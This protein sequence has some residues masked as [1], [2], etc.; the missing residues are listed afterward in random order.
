VDEALDVDENSGS[1]A[2]LTGDHHASPGGNLPADPD[3]NPDRADA[4][5]DADDRSEAQDL[6]YIDEVA[7]QAP[8]LIPTGE[9]HTPDE[10]HER[11]VASH[12]RHRRNGRIRLLVFVVIIALVAA[13]IVKGL[14]GGHKTKPPK[15]H[16]SPVA[17]AGTGPSHLAVGTASELPGNLL[18]ADRGN[19]RLVVV[20]P[21]GQVVWQYPGAS[22]SLTRQLYPDF[23]F[24]TPSGHEIAITEEGPAV[25]DLLDIKLGQTIYRYGDFEVPGSAAN[26]LSDPSAALR[27]GSGILAAD[28]RNC[29]VVVITPP[30]QHVAHQ[31]GKTGRCTHHPP[32][33]LED[34]TTAFPTSDGGVIVNELGG[35]A[36]LFTHGG[37]LIKTMHVPGFSHTSM[38]A[39]VRT[40][41]YISVEHTHPGSVEEFT[42]AGKVLWRYTVK[43]GAGEL[44]D[45]SLASVLPGGNVLVSD[46]YNDRVIVVDPHTDAIVWQYGQ[47]GKAGNGPGYL[48]LPVGF[49][50][51]KPYSLLDKYPSAAPPN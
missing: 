5:P 31:L 27:L 13:F 40:G 3:P 17:A 48:D 2:A 8:D 51:V 37:K 25:I 45:P 10:I 6:A 21:S 44:S 32:T 41:I 50:L 23:A 19:H 33:T 14:P 1:E 9:E 28:I 39:E 26:R 35:Y 18:I 29:R 36:D 49:D 24:F 38:T 7:A 4:S 22:T 30:A 43:K 16:G 46:D 11:R 12:K 15:A 47:R 34:P 42:S 20:S